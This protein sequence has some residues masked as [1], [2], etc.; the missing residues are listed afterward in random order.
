MPPF[1]PLT[2][3]A[4]PGGADRLAPALGRSRAGPLRTPVQAAVAEQVPPADAL[5]AV[6]YRPEGRNVAGLVVVVGFHVLLGWALVNG[7]AR[8]VIEVIKAPLETRLIEEIKPPPP[9]P[10][11][12]PPPRPKLAPPPPAYVPP[13]EVRVA[14]P[15]T[16]APTIT[17]QQV[18]PPP[19]AP[20]VIE[21]PAPPAAA[22]VAAAPVGKPARIDVSTCEKPEYPSAAARASATGT[23]KIRF[24][25]DA[26]GAV[27]KSDIER[28][29]G[30]LRENKLLDR[31]A[32]TA[33]SRCKFTPG[34][35]AS[36]APVGG[37]A[38][39]DYVWRLD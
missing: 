27:S 32:V 6:A 2:F 34:T 3:P 35:D 1:S 11:E 28:S 7:L 31:A 37:F 19:P 16:P 30:G 9:P 33:L 23:T 12:A 20:V 8:S 22:P 5:S 10:L 14:P 17:A 4:M 18:E 13:P 24:T 39:V 38:I 36:G 21:P 29:S 26:A 25:V 15:P